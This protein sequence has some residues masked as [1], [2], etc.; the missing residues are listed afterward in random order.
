MRRSALREDVFRPKIGFRGDSFQNFSLIRIH[1]FKGT[2]QRTRNGRNTKTKKC[3]PHCIE[4][5]IRLFE[6]AAYLNTW[7]KGRGNT[8]SNEW[9]SEMFSKGSAERQKFFPPV[10]GYG[11]EKFL[12]NGFLDARDK[13][14]VQCD[15]FGF[16]SKW[17]S[18]STFIC[19]QTC[20]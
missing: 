20:W 16:N 18:C 10:S 4:R 2:F 14:C 6:N 15:F 7:F 13:L 12:R 3:G 19:N 11:T 9:M 8:A 17:M 1:W 5:P